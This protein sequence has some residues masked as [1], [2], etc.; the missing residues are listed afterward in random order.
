[1]KTIMIFLTS[2]MIF[3]C[4]KSNYTI[5]SEIFN[6]SDRPYFE[7]NSESD[8]YSCK[9][10]NYEKNENLNRKYPLVV[11][12]HGAGSAGKIN[13][14]KYL[15]YQSKNFFDNAQARNFQL[16]H[17]CFVLVP[18]TSGSWD[19]NKLIQLIEKFKKE[20]RIDVTRIYLIGYSMGGYGSYALANAYYKYNNHLFA[21]IIRLAGQSETKLES[22][23]VQNTSVWLHIGLTDRDI[24]IQV[25]REAYNFLKEN[26]P[27]AKET[28]EKAV[29]SPFS[30][31]ILTLTENGTEVAKKTEYNNV[32]HGINSLPFEDENVL[33]WLFK[34]KIK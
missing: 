34:Q 12:L 13:Y 10:W 16:N 8:Y 20:Y 29:V 2:L 30:G 24:R 11:Y 3:S 21:G 17:P 9:P 26:H 32:G 4:S 25:T 28:S 23:I 5:E 1:M 19:N 22:P 31:T 7:Y 27:T 15:G 18:Q 14:L 6:K 33:N